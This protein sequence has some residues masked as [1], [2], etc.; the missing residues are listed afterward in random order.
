MP[1]TQADRVVVRPAH[2]Y[3]PAFQDQVIGPAVTMQVDALFNTGTVRYDWGHTFMNHRNPP[4]PE[5]YFGTNVKVA[6]IDSGV[7][8]PSLEP[9]IARGRCFVDGYAMWDYRDT[10]GHGTH[11]AG[12]IAAMDTGASKDL[13][14]GHAPLISLYVARVCIDDTNW[15]PPNWLKPSIGLL[16]RRLT[17]STCRWEA[18]T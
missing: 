17:S 11:V 4:P 7:D 6:V 9:R 16:I 13:T 14:V 3:Y 2:S 10:Y 8:H 5:K 15:T 18:G 12:I 1:G